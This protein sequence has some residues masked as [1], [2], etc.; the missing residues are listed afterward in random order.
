MGTVDAAFLKSGQSPGLEIWRIEKMKVV[1]QNQVTYGEFFIGDS[2]IV[3]HT[4]KNS[5]SGKLEWNIHFWLGNETSQDEQGVAAY[6]TVELDDFLGGAPVQH[7]EVQ[8]HESKLFL[9]YFTKGI[10]YL[11]GGIESGFRKVEK[12]HYQ[13]RLFH[14]KGK[15]NVRVT[16]VECSC[17]SLNQGD[18]FL[19]D[20]GLVLHLWNGPLS[21][22]F[23]RMKGYQVAK[24]I[25]DEERGGKAEIR[26]IDA[27][28]N[29]DIQFFADL[30]SKTDIAESSTAGDDLEFE[31]KIYSE[32]KLYRVSDSS[33]KMEIVE[34]S[35]K[36][37]HQSD[38]DSNDCFILDAGAS[39]I[40]VWVGR[41]CTHD[42]KKSAWKYA[43]DFL[44]IRGYPNWTSITRVVEGGETPVFKQYFTSWVDVNDQKGL[45]NIYNVGSIAEIQDE[46]NI[47]YCQLHE[48]KQS[49]DD[50][51]F[52]TD[53][54]K[55]RVWKVRN[56]DVEILPESPY[57]ELSSTSCFVI[58]VSFKSNDKIHT[59][60]YYWQ[61]IRS[62]I[63]DRSASAIYTKRICEQES[64]GSTRQIRIDQGREPETFLRIFKGR[65]IIKMN[66]DHL[67]YRDNIMYHI[68]GTNTDNT[69]AVEVEFSS[70]SL[71]SFD[72][73]LIKTKDHV[74]IWVG[75]ISI[76]AEFHATIDLAS[77][78]SPNSPVKIVPEG[79]ESLEFWQVLGGK[80]SYAK[81]TIKQSA[82]LNNQTPV[83][84]F[85]CSNT[86][87]MFK[88]TEI[89]PFTQQDLLEDDVMLLDT[90][91]E[92]YVWVGKGAN[93][94]E[95]QKALE[96]AINYLKSDPTGRTEDDT[97]LI[98]IKQGYEPSTFTSHF[99]GWDHSRWR[100]GLYKKEAF[101]Q[102][103]E[104]GHIS[105]VQEELE[106]LHQNYSYQQL[107]QKR[108]P[109]GVDPIYKEKYLTENEFYQIFGVSKETFYK[110]PKWK[111]LE[112]KKQVGLF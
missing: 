14:I 2:Y 34:K 36:P 55:I 29:T 90:F 30:G 13:K 41:K 91:D 56:G 98:Q 104:T 5:K 11:T 46:A 40:F 6:K 23:E 112:L 42:E 69:K 37:F 58:L 20:C 83:R 24:T 101:D 89:F 111:Q 66:D 92:I 8:D 106:K 70:K 44:D 94:L 65:I 103:A 72:V 26:I 54:L 108:L 12:G 45:G 109:E 85:V 50:A 1:L 16:Q 93:R 102:P 96:T 99:H 100:S 105:T 22:T 86:T 82:E 76:E 110:K 59:I 31:R 68:R 35:K 88:V 73:F 52:I 25:R 79:E 7:R 78:V 51:N 15:K 75:K 18:V 47:D 53:I 84:L 3:L 4:K 27:R 62:N 39:G 38:L 97:R 71:N 60:G 80:E 87:G 33:G 19:L 74:Y 61:G 49:V 107:V 95:R 48:R 81:S 17:R 32:I 64:T 67:T 10:R 28:W 77:Y 21:S 43:S 57:A 9:S 63:D